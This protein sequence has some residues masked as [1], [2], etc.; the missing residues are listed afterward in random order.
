ME[1]V[2]VWSYNDIGRSVIV[3]GNTVIAVR[4]G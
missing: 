4:A 2:K 1:N 3:R